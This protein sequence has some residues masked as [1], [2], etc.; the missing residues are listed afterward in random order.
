MADYC[1]QSDL[2]RAAGGAAKLVQ[3]ADLDADGTADATVLA[4]AINDASRWIDGY[5]ARRYEVPLDE[6]SDVIRRVTAD[7]AVY[8]LKDN[9][10]CLDDR[11]QVKYDQHRDWLEGV[12]EGRINPGVDPPPAKSSAV[13][14]T[15]GD[16]STLTD[17]DGD[18]TTVTRESLKGFW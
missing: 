13:T 8:I 17:S 7:V 10:D 9:R 5:L 1:S 4:E 14:A 15:T 12:S 6:P 18:A 16:R 11:A 2:E 3:L